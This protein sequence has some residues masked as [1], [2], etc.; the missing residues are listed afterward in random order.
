M[1]RGC[2]VA[3]VNEVSLVVQPPRTSAQASVAAAA[4]PTPTRIRKKP[5][6]SKVSLQN[7]A[8]EVALYFAG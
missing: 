2:L 8:N 5:L 1:H 4:L 6:M 7:S 3:G